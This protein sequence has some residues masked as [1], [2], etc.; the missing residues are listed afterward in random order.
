MLLDE[1]VHDSYAYKAMIESGRFHL[2]SPEFQS[3]VE[4]DE[5][6]RRGE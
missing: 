4:A 6:M 3:F 5:A 2:W 1:R